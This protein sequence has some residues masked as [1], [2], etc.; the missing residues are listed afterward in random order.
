MMTLRKGRTPAAEAWRRLRALT[1]MALAF[2]SSAAAEQPEEYEVKAAF[3]LNFT[4]FIE[5]PSESLGLPGTPFVV[6]VAGDDPFGARLEDVFRGRRVLDR[7]VVIERFRTPAE[8]RHCHLLF[9][10]P[11]AQETFIPVLRARPQL[12]RLVVGELEGF[13]RRGGMISFVVEGDR[14]RLAVNPSRAVAAGLRLSSRLLSLARL[15]PPAPE[16][17]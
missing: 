12:G 13:V 8:L 6:G 17:P 16:E 10:S 7:S 9:V 2:A 1:L 3:L 15:V 4:R 5:W 14:V 11:P